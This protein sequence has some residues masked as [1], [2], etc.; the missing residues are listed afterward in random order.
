MKS[1]MH[2]RHVVCPHEQLWRRELPSPR[3]FELDEGVV[4][5]G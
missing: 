1:N 4:N 5:H 3:G 2:L